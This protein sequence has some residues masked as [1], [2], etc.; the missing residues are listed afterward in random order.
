M[1]KFFSD[2]RFHLYVSLIITFL[3]FIAYSNTFNGSFH[4]DDTIHIVDN[5]II[6]DLSNLPDILTNHRGVT[7]ATF[8]LNY[9][10]G[11][12]D[13]FGYHLVNTIIHVVNAILAYFLLFYTLG[14][15]SKDDFWVKKIAAFSAL[16]FALHPVQTQAVTYIVQRMESLS[17]L[18]YLV[19]MLLFV[20]AVQ[21]S[22]GEENKMKTNIKYGLMVVLFVIGFYAKE[23]IIT[24]PAMVLLYDL[25][26]VNKL[27]IKG[28]KPRLPL[29]IAMFGLVIYFIFTTVVPSGGFNDLSGESSGIVTDSAKEG[30][31]QRA[32]L[33]DVSAGFGVKS[34]SPK[35][36][37]YTQFNVIVYY[38]GLLLV[39]ANQ[40]L[41][42]DFPIS[43]GLFEVPKVNQGAV[44]N[45]PIPPPVVSL[46]L[47][48]F[49]VGLAGYYLKKSKDE[50]EFG[51]RALVA[52]FIFWFFII[53]SPTSSVIPIIDV[54]FE[55][56][57]YLASLGYFVIFAV[58]LDYF[59]DKLAEK[60]E[61]K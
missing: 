24:V 51:K 53:L 52:Y 42:Y 3:V 55:H 7:M 60:L 30:G 28:L 37:M 49:V 47:I 16:L 57:V 40:N 4:F 14:Y 32:K 41:D 10:V 25:I 18:F 8:A 45:I 6:R 15:I 38:V 59:F 26:F 50:N 43:R 19:I 58:L 34:I 56:R 54:I 48:L 13:V 9:A 61:K 21:G 2:K 22:D 44:L 1:N 29:Y 12:N 20:K 31:I 5:H 23:I 46:I 36:Y 33:A 35:E 27:D 39:P 17:S 11:G